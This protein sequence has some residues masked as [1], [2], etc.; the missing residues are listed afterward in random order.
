VQEGFLFVSILSPLLD[1]VSLL[2]PRS[3]FLLPHQCSWLDSCH[4]FLLS[5]KSLYL[6]SVTT[7][8]VLCASG[9]HGAG[10]NA[11]SLRRILPSVIQ[12]STYLPPSRILRPPLPAPKR[13]YRLR[14]RH[15]FLPSMPYSHLDPGFLFLATSPWPM[16]SFHLSSP[17]R[18]L[19]DC[20]R[21][22]SLFVVCPTICLSCHRYSCTVCITS[23]WCRRERCLTPSYPPSCHTLSAPVI[24][25]TTDFSLPVTV[26]DPIPF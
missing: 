12:I 23:A 24:N 3:H 18:P 10:G 15:F 6:P 8:P 22:E 19:N 2:H 17:L 25:P 21:L 11:A 14:W 7:A 5:G 26:M 4:L 13:R 1:D 9:V 20:S 16:V